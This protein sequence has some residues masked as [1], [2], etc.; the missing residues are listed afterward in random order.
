MFGAS[1]DYTGYVIQILTGT[2]AGQYRGIVSNTDDTVIIQADW[3]TIPDNTS[4]YQVVALGYKDQDLDGNNLRHYFVPY[5]P[6]I[7][8]NALNI[9]GTQVDLT[10]GVY[11]YNNRAMVL[12]DN[13]SDASIFTANTPQNINFKYIYGIAPIPRVIKR[14]CALM[15]G[16]M[17]VAAKV[18]GSYTDFST[19]SLPGQ[20]S[21]SKG[22]PYVNL[23]AGISE[24]QK[25]AKKITETIYRRFTLFG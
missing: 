20:V 23:Q 17:T 1:F 5:Q 18:N 3:D 8:L 7:E 6:L 11:T 10:S 13:N 4:T 16:M 14:L 25:E 19:I 21:G 24:L 12:L 22:Q 2:G 9:N 15:A